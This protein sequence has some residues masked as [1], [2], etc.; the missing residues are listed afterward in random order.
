MKA[1]NDETKPYYKKIIQISGFRTAL[2]ENYCGTRSVNRFYWK[3][4]K[5][6]I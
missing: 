2:V 5:Y 1:D 4:G 3:I 6:N